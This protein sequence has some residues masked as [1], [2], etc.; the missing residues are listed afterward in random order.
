MKLWNYQKKNDTLQDIGMNKEFFGYDNQK[1][2][3]KNK[4]WQMGLRLQK[5]FCTTKET[6]N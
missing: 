6:I 4:N 3:N 2:H 1:T 5:N